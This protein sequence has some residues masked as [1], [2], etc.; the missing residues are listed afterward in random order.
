MATPAHEMAE[1]M[2]VLDLIRVGEAHGLGPQDAFYAWWV[3]HYPA[4]RRAVSTDGHCADVEC[5]LRLT[6]A[7]ES[8]RL[9]V[10]EE[11]E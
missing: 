9:D 11:D 10:E 5:R 3:R 6:V 1:E 4:A 7:A 8:A 2:T